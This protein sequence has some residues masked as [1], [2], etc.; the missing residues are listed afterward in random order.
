MGTG[1][2]SK[3]VIHALKHLGIEATSVSRK[4][5]DGVL[6][7]SDLNED[8]ISQN[9]LIVNTT[10]LG[11]FPNTDSCPDIP[12]HF[13]SA[14]H[15]CYDLVYNPAETEFMRKAARYGATVKNGL[16]M[17]HLQAEEAWRIWNS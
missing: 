11:M 10:P 15:I 14:K 17:L 5:K 7:Y 6:I 16:E 1:G 12:Y 2:A 13:L 4:R 9:L 3:A 8:I